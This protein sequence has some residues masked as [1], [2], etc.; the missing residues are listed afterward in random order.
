MSDHFEPTKDSKSL[1]EKPAFAHIGTFEAITQHASHGF[2]TDAPF[3]AGT[4]AGLLTF[5]N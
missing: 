5:S 1:Y 3:P 4:P 2:A